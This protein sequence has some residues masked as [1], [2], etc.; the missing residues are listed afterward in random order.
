MTNRLKRTS[1]YG[2]G[3]SALIRDFISLTGKP[4][5]QSLLM[6]TMSSSIS[7]TTDIFNALM[8]ECKFD[9]MYHRGNP[10]PRLVAIQ[11]E[12]SRSTSS[13]NTNSPSST[14]TSQPVYRHPVDVS[15]HVETFT[16]TVDMIRKQIEKYLNEKRQQDRDQE[17]DQRSNAAAAAH[18]KSKTN[19]TK[20]SKHTQP[21]HS[22]SSSLSS[23]SSTIPVE[24]V[25]LNHCLIQYYRD[26]NDH[27]GDHSDKTLDIQP[28]SCVVNYSIY[29]FDNHH[30]D[31]QA[32]HSTTTTKKKKNKSKKKETV[33]YEGPNVIRSMILTAKS[34][35]RSKNKNSKTKPMSH[36]FP[37]IQHVPLYNNSLLSWAILRTVS[38]C[39]AFIGS[40]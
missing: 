29:P 13:T 38:I 31:T 2:I 27:I 5:E 35:I 18:S 1:T 23:S 33:F 37:L 6:R 3:D 21:I 12:T 16:P 22:S 36:N 9:S 28:D 10:V 17:Q 26:G 15:P 32:E 4:S 19:P 20:Q 7:S 40:D 14:L 8:R 34:K 25:F 24:P 30:I 39:M 11:C